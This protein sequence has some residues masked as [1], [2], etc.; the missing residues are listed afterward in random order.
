MNLMLHPFPTARQIVGIAFPFALSTIL[1][2]LFI[3]AYGGYVSK[4]IM[5][6]SGTI[7]GGK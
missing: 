3:R 6:L 7:A 4:D 5:L 1:T 2:R